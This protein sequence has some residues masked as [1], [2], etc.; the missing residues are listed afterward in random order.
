MLVVITMR[1]WFWFHIHLTEKYCI[2]WKLIATSSRSIMKHN[3]EIPQEVGSLFY[4]TIYSWRCVY[5]WWWLSTQVEPWPQPKPSSSV[6]Q[7]ND[8]VFVMAVNF[9][10]IEWMNYLFGLLQFLLFSVPKKQN[11]TNKLN[12]ITA[13]ITQPSSQ[14]NIV[15][16]GVMIRLIVFLLGVSFRFSSLYS[17]VWFWFG[18]LYGFSWMRRCGF[19]KGDL[20]SYF[21]FFILV[22]SSF[23]VGVTFKWPGSAA[24][25]LLGNVRF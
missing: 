9:K 6:S 7:V 5:S 14:H 23:L 11:L 10:L 21:F 4:I 3:K 15:V 24:L 16:V 19:F 25:V 22:S 18:V 8:M 20:F 1:W 2:S 13:A 17:F 12:E